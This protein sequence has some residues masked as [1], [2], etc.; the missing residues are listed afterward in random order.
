M[1]VRSCV[2]VWERACFR[3]KARARTKLFRRMLSLSSASSMMM[4]MMPPSSKHFR[5]NNGERHTQLHWMVCSHSVSYT[6]L[7]K[8]Q[9]KH[10]RR[11]LRCRR[12][13]SFPWLPCRRRIS[14]NLGGIGQLDWKAELARKYLRSHVRPCPSWWGK[15]TSTTRQDHRRRAVPSRGDCAID[16]QSRS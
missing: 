7:R 5:D 14:G 6:V 3:T 2:Y 1:F 11:K 9:F 13:L 10:V 16:D 8:D 4:M 12:E 15:N